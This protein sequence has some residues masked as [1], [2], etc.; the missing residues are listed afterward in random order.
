MTNYTSVVIE[1]LSRTTRETASVDQIMLR[2]CIALASS[3]LITDTAMNPERGLST[4]YAGFSNLIDVLLALHVR[5]EL[6]LET[7]NAAS[8][9]CSECW[10]IA[11]TWRELEDCRE[12]V[13]NVAS[14][15]RSILDA[16]RRTYRGE[17]VYAP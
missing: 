10:G 11:G 7:F 9:A 16:N 15:L 6:E 17:G 2:Q 8:K 3:Y 14:K 1:V 5:G 13:R 12:C 4:W